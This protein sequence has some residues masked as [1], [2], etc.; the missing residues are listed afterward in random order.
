MEPEITQEDVS[1]VETDAGKTAAPSQEPKRTEKEKAA[2]TLQKTAERL[3]ELGGD[4]LKALGAESSDE[5]P[6]WYKKMVADNVKQTALQLADQIPD[7]NKRQEVKDTL[8]RLTPSGDAQADFRLAFGAVSSQKNKQILE[9]L[10]RKQ[11]PRVTA[12]GG[13]QPIAVEDEFVPTQEE[14]EMMRP[15]FNVPKAK[16]IA[17]RQRTEAKG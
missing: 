9:E 15:P 6:A 14:V 3:K 11:A 7:E 17:A 8:A 13:S 5:V 10:N 12:S 2:Y 16:I 4:P 1:T